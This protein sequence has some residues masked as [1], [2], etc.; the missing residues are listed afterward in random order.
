VER[1]SSFQDLERIFPLL[2]YPQIPKTIAANC[3]DIWMVQWQS[4]IASL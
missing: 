1:Q 2:L 3:G 4:D